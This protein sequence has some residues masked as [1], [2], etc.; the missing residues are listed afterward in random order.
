MHN[1]VLVIL[2]SFYAQSVSTILSIFPFVEFTAVYIM[3]LN[4]ERMLQRCKGPNY[5]AQP[6]QNNFNT[7]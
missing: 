5:N 6:S 2:M 4:A 3:D 1:A 7:V